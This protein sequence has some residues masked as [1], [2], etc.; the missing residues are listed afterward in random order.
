MY[1]NKQK[2]RVPVGSRAISTHIENTIQKFKI[3]VKQLATF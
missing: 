3:K 1:A 2:A